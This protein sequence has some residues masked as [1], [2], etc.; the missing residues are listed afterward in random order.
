MRKEK[1]WAKM[2]ESVLGQNFWAPAISII[3]GALM[4]SVSI[5]GI[6]VHHRLLSGGVSGLALVIYYLVPRLSIGL[7]VFL[8]NIPIFLM[9]WTMISGKFFAFSLLGMVSFSFFLEVTT[10]LQVFVE[11]PLLAC[12]FAGVISGVGSGLIFRAGGSGGGTGIIA[13]VLNRRFSVRVGFVSF[14]LNSVPLV[15]GAFLLDLNA[16]LYSIIYVYTSGS[17]MD[18]IITSFSE[19]RSVWI[20][21]SQSSEICGQILTKLRRGATLLSGKG[22]YTQSPIEVIYSVISP[23]ELAKLK[24]LV[25]T[26]DPQAFL[27][28]N[29]TQEVI[30]KGFD[31]PTGF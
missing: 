10:K 4:W 23:F 25:I 13:M 24:D 30:G 26:I 31:Q 9:G 19:R 15:L 7:M 14:F 22:A 21:S 5:N 6:L 12:L 16:A 1:V 11:N 20:I 29:E 17:V 3:L 2:R 28:V 27:I 18:R 8:I